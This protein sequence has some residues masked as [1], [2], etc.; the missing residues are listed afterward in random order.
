M[1]RSFD[2]DVQLDHLTE[3][4]RKMARSVRGQVLEDLS[5]KAAEPIREE[6]A[7]NVTRLRKYPRRRTVSLSL[8]RHIIKKVIKKTS[9]QVD[10]KIGANYKKVKH[11][12][13]IE[14]GAKEHAVGKGKIKVKKLHPGAE[15][16]LPVHKAYEAK[17]AEAHEI[18]ADGLL[19]KIKEE[20]G[21]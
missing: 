18:L 1:S 17:Q 3:Q 21:Q 6:A 11:G 10:V 20:T 2:I 13:L 12:H 4:F 14:F 15:G 7:R 16:R 8:E 19:Q 5:L 9:G